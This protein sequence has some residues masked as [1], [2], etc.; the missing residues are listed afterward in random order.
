[1]NFLAL[2]LTMPDINLSLILPELIVC[3]IAVVVMLVDALSR[4][5][6]RWITGGISLAGLIAAAISSGWL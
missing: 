1:M 4:A 3:G 2:Q 5:T 6:Q